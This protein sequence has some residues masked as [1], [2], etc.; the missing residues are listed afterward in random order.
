MTLRLGGSTSG[1]TDLDAPAVAGNN[2]IRLPSGNGTAGQLLGGDG[3]GNLSWVGGRMV[4]EAVKTTTSGTTVDFTS[5]P[6]WTKR[7]TLS[8]AGVSVSGTSNIVVRLGDSGGIETNGYLGATSLVGPT[9]TVGSYAHSSASGF[10]LLGATPGGA[11]ADFHGSLVLT[12]VDEAAWLWAC[13]GCMARTDVVQ[14]SMIAGSKAL[15]ATLDRLQITTVNGTDTFD[16]G[17]ANI[18]YQG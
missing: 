3:A 12:L 11:G 7:I 9:T 13:Q 14:V 15:T 18:L 2:T 16:A 17:K 4:L 1:Y 10:N 6:S 8:L 5:I